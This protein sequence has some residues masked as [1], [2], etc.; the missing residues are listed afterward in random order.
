MFPIYEVQ[1]TDS[2]AL[3][4]MGSKA[5]FWFDHED[6]G[7]CLFKE[8]RPN[9]GEDW[10][11]KVAAEIAGLLGLPHAEYELAL[12][13]GA[14]GVITPRLTA[15]DEE[16]VHGNEL[17]VEIDPAYELK[18]VEYRTPAHTVSS[19]VR[20]LREAAGGVELPDGVE[21]PVEVTDAVGVLA[22]YLLF[23][24][25]IGNTDRH[26]E[27]WALI[28][29]PEKEGMARYTVAPTFDHASSLGRNES[30]ERVQERLATS[31][32]GFT[33]EAY[34][35]KARS[36]LFSSA[37]DS[38]PLAPLDAFREITQFSHQ[39][40]RA[41]CQRLNR[42]TR[43]ALQGILD[44]VPDDRMPEPIKH[45]VVRMVMFNR[46]QIAAVCEEL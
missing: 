38:A 21:L 42:V 5:K 9:T 44:R 45:F 23:D 7:P 4:P 11:E 2:Q 10:S 12:C 17:L 22:G 39:T 1:A 40:A 41:W 25:L 37:D 31:D 16:L 26:H 36:A 32:S 34:A 33:V 29:A 35:A 19:V 43:G 6:L 13:E 3:E 27:N 14:R 30:L 20:A 18:S 46:Q 28:R 24:A 15:D 8:A